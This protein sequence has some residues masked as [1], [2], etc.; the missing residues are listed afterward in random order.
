[1]GSE[2]FT[3]NLH[4]RCGD[5]AA[6]CGPPGQEGGCGDEQAVAGGVGAVVVAPQRPQVVADAFPPQPVDRVGQV[7][8]GDGPLLAVAGA[9]GGDPGEVESALVAVAEQQRR[10]T[11]DLLPEGAYAETVPV[12]HG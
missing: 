4:E 12:E 8:G 2:R 1:M 11:D 9:E 5:R 10:G 3:G 6:V 7:G